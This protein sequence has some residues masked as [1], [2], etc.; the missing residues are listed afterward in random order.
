MESASAVDG[1]DKAGEEEDREEA[2]YPRTVDQL[3]T[4]AAK[5]RK[6]KVN[7]IF[8]DWRTSG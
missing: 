7:A 3:S 6:Y 8:S 4:M 1:L 2:S 5:E